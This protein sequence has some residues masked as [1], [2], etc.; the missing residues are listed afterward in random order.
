[1]ST[2]LIYVHPDDPE[3]VLMG[4]PFAEMTPE[5]HKRAILLMRHEI[6][7]R[8]RKERENPSPRNRMRGKYEY[9]GEWYYGRALLSCVMA[10]RE[11]PKEITADCFRMPW[12]KII[13]E[14]LLSMQ[15]VSAGDFQKYG[16]L[17]ALLSENPRFDQSFRKYLDEIFTMIG[18]VG[19][20]HYYAQRLLMLKAGIDI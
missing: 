14:A 19:N 1:V 7:H 5:E 16:L 8:R 18:P 17:V 15:N 13:F 9:R 10:G 3:K 4:K 6:H 12:N 11:I 20:A 2:D